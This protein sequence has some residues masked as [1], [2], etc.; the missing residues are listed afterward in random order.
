MQFNP[1]MPQFG[2]Y[3]PQFNN[4]IQQPEQNY[5]QFS[6]PAQPSYPQN[7]QIYPQPTIGLQGKLIDN[8][9]V[10]KV[11]EI[12][13]D[14]S[15]SYFPLAD[16]SAIVTK[17]LQADGTSKVM[18]YKPSVESEKPLETPQ[19]IT[20]DKV[21]ELIKKEPESTKELKEEIKNLK[22]QLRDMSEDLRELREMREARET[23]ESKRKSD[24]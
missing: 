13:M 6:Q 16:G 20:E 12:P 8:P 7:P 18:I 15:V 9:E 2:G 10:V 11:T 1:Y 21:I 5:Q 3:V 22:R 4:R 17:Q 14:G 23:R 24:D 19:Y